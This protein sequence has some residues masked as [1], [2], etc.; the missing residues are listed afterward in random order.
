M[1]WEHSSDISV[2]VAMS[3]RATTKLI[4]L[5]VSGI[6]LVMLVLNAVIP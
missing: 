4:G 3:E 6:F 1:F 2:L 5:S